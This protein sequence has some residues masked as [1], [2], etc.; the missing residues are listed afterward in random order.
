MRL[1]VDTYPG[2]IA[3][4]V[5]HG[6]WGHFR[7]FGEHTSVGFCDKQNKLAAGAVFHAW[8]QGHGTIELSLYF[9]KKHMLTRDIGRVIMIHAFYDTKIRYV[10]GSMSAENKEMRRLC[11]KG[12]NST[13]YIL[14]NLWSDGVDMVLQTIDRQQWRSSP[15]GRNYEPV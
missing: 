9:S 14:K 12:F 8:H 6:I 3:D 11:T 7:N 4:F 15:I 5:A 1:Y 2:E 10:I 13:E